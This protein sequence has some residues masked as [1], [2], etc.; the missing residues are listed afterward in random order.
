CR[1][2]FGACTGVDRRPDDVARSSQ[3]LYQAELP[4]RKGPP[5]RGA[6]YTSI[7]L[8]FFRRAR[9]NRTWRIATSSTR[10]PYDAASSDS[11]SWSWCSSDRRA[12]ERQAI[13]TP[14]N[15]RWTAAEP[16]FTRWARYSNAES[17]AARASVIRYET[18]SRTPIGTR[19][20]VWTGA[21]SICVSRRRT[22]TRTASPRIQWTPGFSSRTNR[23]SR[24]TSACSNS[25]TLIRWNTL[26]V[27]LFRQEVRRQHD[28]RAA[29]GDLLERLQDLQ[30]E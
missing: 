17:A 9:G 21:T 28:L 25:D 18:C 19:S 4:P 7:R 1:R 12:A 15:D 22:S 24:K 2:G 11:R 23:P 14:E 20:S 5:S 13:A 29:L 10:R 3:A 16:S 27:L 6:R 30:L 26:T 8:S